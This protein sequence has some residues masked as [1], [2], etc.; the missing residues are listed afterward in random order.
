VHEADHSADLDLV[1]RMLAGDEEAFEMFGER[2]FKMLYRF[3]F[4]RLRDGDLTR[5]IVQS[6]MAKALAKLATYRGEAALLTWLCSCCRNEI[7]M[8]FRQ[9]KT[10]PVGLELSDEMEADPG[11]HLQRPGDPGDPETALLKRERA[12]LV[13]MALDGLPERYARA[14]EWKYL[15]CIPVNEIA[16]RLGVGPKAA[17]SLLTRARQAFRTGYESLQAALKEPDHGRTKS[18]H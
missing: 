3:V 13:H 11:F 12:G 16:W 10:A 17:E 4:A 1:G 6:A 15:D 18:D 7:L 14:L 5:E 9:R 2:F 8:Y